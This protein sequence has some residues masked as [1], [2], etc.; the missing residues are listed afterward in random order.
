MNRRSFAQSVGAGAVFSALANAQGGAPSRKTGIYRLDY[1]Y[2][3][4]GE[5]SNRINQFLSSQLTLLTRDTRAYGVF[6]AV[7]APHVPT[8]LILRGYGSF[9]EM[10]A[11]ND[12]LGRDAG[13]R[14]A[15]EKMEAGPE[16]P[17][18]RGDSVLLR[19]TD[20]ASDI[21]PLKEKPKT[22]RVFEM[23]IYHSPTERQLR[24]LHE[25]FA[26]PEIG[27]FHRSGIHPI[28]YSDTL[29]GPNMPNLTYLIPF[30]SLA[31]REKAWDAFSA[32]PEWVKVRAE[33]VAKGGQINA[34]SQYTFWRPLPFSP[35]Q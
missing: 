4:Q 30:A 31:D 33:S 8:T 2:F 13:F 12:R 32:D 34:E 25:R 35:I 28:L 24:L 10:Q 29:I 9:E 16:P 23:R 26:G 22:P 18:D 14:A 11:A 17:F 20:F 5:Q 21:V 1:L 6:S 15:H 3:R 7:I 19:P 27:I